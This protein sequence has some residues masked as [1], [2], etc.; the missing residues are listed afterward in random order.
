MNSTVVIPSRRS[1]IEKR[2]ASGGKIAAVFPIHYPRALFWAHGLLPVEVWGPPGAER[3]PAGSH[4]QA[5]TCDIVHAGLGFLLSGGLAAADAIVAPHGCDSLQGLGSI[6]L[7]FIPPAQPVFPFYLPRATR[8]AD[9]DYFAREIESL[10]RQLSSVSGRTPTQDE[11]HKAIAE[12]EAADGELERLWE[13]RAELPLDNQTLYALSR[14]RGYL[15]PQEFCD[16]ARQ[17]QAAAAPAASA[18]TVVISGVIAEPAAMLSLLDRAGIRVGADD[19]LCL[20]RRFYPAG[21]SDD[22]Y[23]RMAERIL[24]APPDSTRG[25]AIGERGERLLSLC[26]RAGARGVIFRLVKFCEPEQFYLPALR[27]ALDEAN[28]PHLVLETDLAADLDGP[29]QTRLEAFLEM[30]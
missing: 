27:R 12:D 21:R 20:G 3:A 18:K 8:E 14:A 23:R 2:K 11:L 4:L 5:Y 29:S 28:I 25:S 22:P 1:A 30:L 24:S 19:T 10:S 15:A 17:A 16:L 7:D 9:I 6:L 13:R 26:R